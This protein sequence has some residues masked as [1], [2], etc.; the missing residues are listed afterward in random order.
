M[1]ISD[2]SGDAGVA[3]QG[4]QVEVDD[5]G[6]GQQPDQINAP[7]TRF[8]IGDERWDVVLGATGSTPPA[9]LSFVQEWRTRQ[10]SNL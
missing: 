7:L 3:D 10:D 6:Q 9:V 4:M 5:A 1:R 8:N 2:R